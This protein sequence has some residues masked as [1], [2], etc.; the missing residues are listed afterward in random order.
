VVN[1]SSKEQVVD[2][3]T[4]KEVLYGKNTFFDLLNNTS[5]PILSGIKIPAVSFQLF[6]LK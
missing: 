6:E 4:Y 1:T 2:S 3:E 5:Q